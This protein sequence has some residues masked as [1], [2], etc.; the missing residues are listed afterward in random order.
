M[1][2]WKD[3][4]TLKSA[5][6]VDNMLKEP[7]SWERQ[8]LEEFVDNTVYPPCYAKIYL[9]KAKDAPH[10]PYITQLIVTVKDKET[11]KYLVKTSPTGEFRSLKKAQAWAESHPLY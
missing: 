10:I 9:I 3:D 5:K 2:S 7:I 4:N 8:L 1:S 11:T 6:E